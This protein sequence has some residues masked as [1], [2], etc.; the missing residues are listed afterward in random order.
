MK[1]IAMYPGSFDPITKGHLNIIERAAALFDKLVVC[2]VSNPNKA[3]TYTL[4]EREAMI[5]KCIKNLDNVEIDSHDGLLADYVN[6]HDINVVI[7]G[8]RNASD[9]NNEYEMSM[10]NS[11][12]YTNGAET[13]CLMTAPEHDYI[14]SSAVKEIAK[15]GGD[16][17]ALVPK[18]IVKDIKLMEE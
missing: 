13:V 2:V 3:C 7:R 6:S 12:L 1:R 5:K 10:L 8:I 4:S 14:S 9:F 16:V 18:S 17:S 11:N 15:L